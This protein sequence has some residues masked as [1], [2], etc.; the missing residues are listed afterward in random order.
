MY[1]VAM[2]PNRTQKAL[3]RI[4]APTEAEL[5]RKWNDIQEKGRFIYEN[6]D[7][8]DPDLKAALANK[9]LDEFLSDLNRYVEH[10]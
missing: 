1:C 10:T 6:F 7:S 9:L 2:W 8:L 5:I 4:S 3:P